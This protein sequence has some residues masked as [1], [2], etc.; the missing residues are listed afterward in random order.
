MKSGLARITSNTI[1]L[2]FS[3]AIILAVLEFYFRFFDPQSLRLSRPDAVLGWNHIP[4]TSGF[5]RKE[6][7]STELDFNSEGMRDIEHEAGKPKGTYRIAVIGD[8]Y[9]TAQEVAFDEAFFRQLQHLLNRRGHN[10]EVLGFGVRG[11]GT[12]QEFRL[13][14]RYALRYDPDLVILA[15]VPNDIH[16]N[17]VALE[18]NPAKP[19]FDLLPDGRL[20]QR[21]FAP[22][23]DHSNS[24]KSVLFEN[25][26][27]VRFFYYRVAQVPVLHNALVRFGVYANVVEK[28]EGPD[29]LM[30]NTVFSEPPWSPVWEAA[31]HVTRELL[32]EFRSTSN[33]S[34]AE[35]VLFSVTKGIQVDD[36][37]FR[38]LE[39]RHPDIALAYD[40]LDKKLAAFTRHEGIAYVSSLSAMRELQASGKSVHLACDGHW[41]RDAHQRAA[42]LLADYLV[43]GGYI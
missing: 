2:V 21:P 35:F 17:S 32:R 43:T 34:G 28:P 37:E 30:K 26:H 29:D 16:N 38:K 15:F 8:S 10:V 12:D 36:A 3:L 14:E 7:F 20:L 42:E 33:N 22:M 25:L 6:C 4:N 24:W 11:F 39:E 5:W 1:L 31:W 9:V 23:P 18:K 27:V 41:S 13:L 40:N 19:Y